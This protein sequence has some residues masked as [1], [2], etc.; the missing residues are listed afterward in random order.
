VHHIAIEYARGALHWIRWGYDRSIE[1]VILLPP[2]N[3]SLGDIKQLADVFRC[4]AMRDEPEGSL[5]QVFA[6]VAINHDVVEFAGFTRKK[7]VTGLFF[8]FKN[9]ACQGLLDML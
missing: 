7:K 2:G 3:A 9:D 6:D 8:F 4:I 5:L 1:V